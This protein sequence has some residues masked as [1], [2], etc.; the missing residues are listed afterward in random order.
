[1]YL[2]LSFCR[3]A[4]R[5]CT[6]RSLNTRRCC[7]WASAWCRAANIIADTAPT[8][9]THRSKARQRGRHALG[10]GARLERLKRAALLQRRVFNYAAPLNRRAAA[11]PA[12]PMTQLTG[13]LKW[14]CRQSRSAAAA[15]EVLPCKH[16]LAA[17]HCLPARPVH[18]QPTFKLLAS[19]L[20]GVQGPGDLHI[21][22]LT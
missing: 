6:G 12:A 21:R 16:Q 2:Q 4:W 17:R 8:P 5:A 15:A 3:T 1:M 10:R 11:G 22:A 18:R 13:C 19:A 14:T 7:H 9:A 20:H